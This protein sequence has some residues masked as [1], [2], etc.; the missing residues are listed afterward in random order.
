MC[1]QQT[2][3]CYVEISF[4]RKKVR[5]SVA[6]GPN[7][8]WNESLTLNVRPPG[9]DFRP[10]NLLESNVGMELIY[11]NIFDEFM[12][13]LVE[14]ERDRDYEIHQRRERNWLGGFSMPFTA[15]YEQTRVK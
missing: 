2:V 3:R 10:E 4:Q 11:F 7:P 1:F 14:D 9:D 8:T 5:T 6:D 12:V 13:D 15:L